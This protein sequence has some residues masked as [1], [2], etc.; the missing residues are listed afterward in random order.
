MQFSESM[1]KV[2]APRRDVQTIAVSQFFQMHQLPLN[3]C[4]DRRV[5]EVGE[6]GGCV[7]DQHKG[8][9][10]MWCQHRSLQD[11]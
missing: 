7:V 5:I 1:Q 6:I 4:L 3:Q 8:G 2:T 11:P 10:F 9:H